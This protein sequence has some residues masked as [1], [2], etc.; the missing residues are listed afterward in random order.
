[1]VHVPPNGVWQSVD[2]AI[3][4]I[5]DDPIIHDTNNKLVPLLRVL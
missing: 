2:P 3:N 5:A 1:M 4:R